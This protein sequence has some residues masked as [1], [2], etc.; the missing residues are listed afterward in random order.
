MDTVVGLGS[1]GCNIAELFKKYPQYSVYKIDTDVEGENCYEVPEQN[2]PEDYERRLPD[3]GNF[4]RHIDGDVLFIVAGG[5]KITGATLK[6][7]Q[8]IKHCNINI[9]YIKPDNKSLNNIS[10]LQNKLTYNVLQEYTRSGLINRMFIVSNEEL[11]NIIGDVSILEH[12]KK[13][14]EY[15]VTIIHYINVFNNTDPIVDN[16]EQPKETSRIVTFGVHDMEGGEETDLF[17]LQNI[18]DKCYYYAINETSLKTDGKLLKKIKEHISKNN[19]R[20]SYEIHSTKHSQSFCYYLSYSNSIQPL[21][22]VK[23]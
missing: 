16:N 1:A 20:A 19:I 3:M 10:F 18:T 7:L 9:L 6:I 8:Y 13:L 2:T 21:D 12:D 23:S 17:D 15:L 4:L 14:N 22:I 5:G 11:E